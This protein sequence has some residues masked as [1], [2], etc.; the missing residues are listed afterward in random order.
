MDS[1][2]EQ[3]E[4]EKGGGFKTGFIEESSAAINYSLSDNPRM[5]N[6]QILQ[7]S[8]RYL[9][10][11]ADKIHRSEIIAILTNE[12]GHIATTIGNES[13]LKE[14]DDLPLTSGSSVNKHVIGSS[15]ISLALS[16]GK[17]V[18]QPGNLSNRRFSRWTFSAT[19]IR[20]V[21]GEVLGALCF[22]E[23]NSRKAALTYG[24]LLAVQQVI[25]EKIEN[26]AM[27]QQ[28]FNAQHYAFS[29]IN[30]LSFGVF[31]INLQ[32][33]IVWA[34]DT[35][36]RIINIKRR[37]I[38]NKPIATLLPSWEKIKKRLHNEKSFREEEYSFSIEKFNRIFLFNAYLIHSPGGEIIGYQLSFR[39]IKHLLNVASKYASITASYRLEDIIFAS[40]KMRDLIEYA[41][42]VA[43][44]PISVL[45]TGESG[46]GKEIF[47]QAIHNASERKHACFV[48]INCSA[49][50]PSLIE[51]ELFGYES[52]A[53]TGAA[54]GGRIG[55]FE[56]ANGG[57]LFLDEIGEMPLEMQTKLL[58]V[59]QE[60]KFSRVGGNE[61]I[62]VDVRIIAATNKNL[63]EE[64][65]HNRFRLDLFY[66]INV[67]TI[68]L[69]PLRERK[70]DIKPLAQ[71]FLETKA[72]K[73][74][75]P[76]VR[77]SQTLLGE[78]M[79]YS[80]PGNVRELENYIEKV[81][82]L[83]QPTQMQPSPTEQPPSAT[84]Q[85]QHREH[86]PKSLAEI[87]KEAIEKTL[88]V[89]NANITR[90]ASILGIGRNT[91]YS[92]IKRYRIK[93]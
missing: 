52:G 76:M 66:R 65:K 34:N 8:V 71:Y 77:L 38:V 91:L 63:E 48:A 84:T 75:K 82:I 87:E 56:M 85:I 36:C 67:I 49:I 39:P 24:F 37:L 89:T 7:D 81:T 4:Q 21:N 10:Q 72:I 68:N 78:M 59:I 20:Y 31:A 5:N 13:L 33:K 93:L 19:P 23:K 15:A 62:T 42:I 22:I 27:Q 61:L 30:Q 17:P 55:K 47:A 26:R 44:S 29:M 79:S 3:E 64:V 70:E 57:T 53:F 2:V 43:H 14:A 11:F 60:G 45:I 86:S 51:S 16:T 28:L 41:R 80:W 9:Q 73:L 58:R 46:T 18:Q 83:S 40:N 32:G 88:R 92:K 1:A 12:K 6:A 50:S 90:T 54:K 25:E 74:N 69:P 35:G